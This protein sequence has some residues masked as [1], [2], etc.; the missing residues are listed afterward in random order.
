MQSSYVI[1]LISCVTLS[2][3]GE[4]WM[5]GLTVLDDCLS[6]HLKT[7]DVLNKYLTSLSLHLTSL[8]TR[9]TT[10]VQ[11][12]LNELN[13]KTK[14]IQLQ[15]LRSCY[16][17]IKENLRAHWII[18]YWTRTPYNLI[19]SSRKRRIKDCT[20]HLSHYLLTTTPHRIA[21]SPE[22]KQSTRMISH[23]TETALKLLWSCSEIKQLTRIIS[24]CSESALELLW[25]CSKTTA[26]TNK[27]R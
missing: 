2:T 14:M 6:N 21:N 11:F 7:K 20:R 17:S 24:H 23:C 12:L 26:A 3:L 5:F 27:I 1:R 4:L 19:E 22:I 13:W 9:D 18:K 25:N 10:I 15:Q 8:L 16:T